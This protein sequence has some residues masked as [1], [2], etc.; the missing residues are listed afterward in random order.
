MGLV[1]QLL[2][3]LLFKYWDKDFHYQATF[4]VVTE[5]LILNLHYQISE[6]EAMFDFSNKNNFYSFQLVS[7]HVHQVQ[8][9]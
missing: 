4:I 5:Q 9:F 8:K 7:Q 2:E 3:P 1:G 6:Y